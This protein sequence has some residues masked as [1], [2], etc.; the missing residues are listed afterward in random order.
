MASGELDNVESNGDLRSPASTW[1]TA[2]ICNHLGRQ[3]LYC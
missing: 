3:S 1:G 2:S